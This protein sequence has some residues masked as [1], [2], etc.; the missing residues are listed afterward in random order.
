MRESPESSDSQ[1]TASESCESHCTEFEAGLRRILA[2][3]N[4]KRYRRWIANV[5]A[6]VLVFA[7]FERLIFLVFNLITTFFISPE[8]IFPNFA[9]YGQAL[10]AIRLIPL[11]ITV[12][13][14]SRLSKNFRIR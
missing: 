8:D 12:V 13:I 9:A 2:Y 7:L 1:A 5:L 11:A 10:Y 3:I 4:E 14:F 6:F